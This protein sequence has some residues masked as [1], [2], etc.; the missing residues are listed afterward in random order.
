MESR[1]M[2]NYHVRFG[3]RERRVLSE[4]RPSRP[5]AE[6]GASFLCAHAGI[7]S[8]PLTENSAAYLQGWLKV[9]KADK[10]LLFKAAAEAQKAVNRILKIDGSMD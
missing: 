6:M 9:L 7:D 5:N 10:K 2:G 8:A 3:G 1:M 4:A